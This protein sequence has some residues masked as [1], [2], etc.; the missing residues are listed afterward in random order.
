MKLI[1]T[2]I[3]DNI[4]EIIK[5]LINYIY[6]RNITCIIC[7]NPIQLTNS[8]SLC[9]NWFNKLSFILDGC[10]KCGK[11]IVNRNLDRESYGF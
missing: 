8:Y 4:K 10:N 9:K 5:I 6:P 3:P 11:P 7:D 1:S 2:L